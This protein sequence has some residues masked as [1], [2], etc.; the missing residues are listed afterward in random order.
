MVFINVIHVGWEATHGFSGCRVPTLHSLFLCHIFLK[1][2]WMW[3]GELLMDFQ[4]IVFLPSRACFSTTFLN[5]VV[6]G[7]QGHALSKILLLRQ[8]LFLCQLTFL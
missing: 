3:V 8:R 2:W 6:A 4:D 5:A 7:K 1:L